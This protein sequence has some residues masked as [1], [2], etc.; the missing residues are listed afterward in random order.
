MSYNV[1]G[2]KYQWGDEEHRSF[3]HVRVCVAPPKAVAHKTLTIGFA[4]EESAKLVT[5][6][7]LDD[8]CAMHE[9]ALIEYVSGKDHKN[10]R[11]K[12]IDGVKGLGVKG[13]KFI[14]SAT[15]AIFVE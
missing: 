7:W 4:D 2:G 8:F 10:F 3:F 14:I 9:E 6:K 1:T 15:N 5:E 11:Q 12:L 13:G